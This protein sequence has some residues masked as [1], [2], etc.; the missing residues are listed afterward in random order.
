VR[1]SLQLINYLALYL[2]DVTGYLCF[3]YLDVDNPIEKS[4]DEPLPLFEL[5]T[6]DFQRTKTKL[7]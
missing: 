7:I 5:M 2:I 6:S 4:F 1:I 3:D